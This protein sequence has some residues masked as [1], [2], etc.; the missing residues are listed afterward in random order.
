MNLSARAT[1]ITIV[2]A[3]KATGIKAPKIT[4]A[5][6]KAT[7]ISNA[8]QGLGLPGGTLIAA[9]ADALGD[10]RDPAADP[11]VQ[12]IV[13]MSAIAG[14]GVMQGVAAIAFDDF[15]AVCTDERDKLV[16]AWQAPFNASADELDQAHDRIGDIPLGETGPILAMGGDAAK[17]W[18]KANDAAHVI[19]TIAAGWFAL[20]TLTR[21]VRDDPRYRALR[22][23]DVDYTDWIRAALERK[24]LAPWDAILAGLSLSLPSYADYTERVA[25]ITADEDAARRADQADATAYATGRPLPVRVPR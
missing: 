17:M 13:V 14:E 8:G 5:F 11:A 19:D 7:R 10:D 16:D 2:D 15:R 12:R 20:G 25:R 22:T 3:I 9:V 4:A 1:A 18:A 24:R 21:A 6:D 23:V